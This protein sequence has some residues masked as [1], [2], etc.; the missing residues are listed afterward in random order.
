MLCGHNL[1]LAFFENLQLWSVVDSQLNGSVN[2]WNNFEEF[3]IH[4][5]NSTGKL[6]GADFVSATLSTSFFSL[7][8]AVSDFFGAIDR[9]CAS[10]NLTYPEAMSMFDHLHSLLYV[11]TQLDEENMFPVDEIDKFKLTFQ[12]YLQPSNS[13]VAAQCK[14]FSNFSK[15]FELTQTL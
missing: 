6:I 15:C 4:L 8:P 3:P 1:G 10:P 2:F 7:H 13:T 9:A 14:F 11:I 12:A 5:A